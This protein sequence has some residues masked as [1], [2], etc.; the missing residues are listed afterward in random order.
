MASTSDC[1]G[2]CS[3]P[4]S[5]S[6]D[7]ADQNSKSILRLSACLRPPFACQ[8]F[9]AM[10]RTHPH[11]AVQAS[12]IFQPNIFAGKVIFVTGG[13]SGICYHQTQAM[14]EMGCDAAI[15][16]RRIALAQSSAKALEAK[17]GRKCLPLNGDVRQYEDLV[18]AVKKTVARY[19]RIDYVVCGAAGNFLS[20]VER[21]S[22]NAFKTVIEIDLVS[23]GR[24]GRLS[25]GSKVGSA[26]QSKLART[27]YGCRSCTFDP[28]FIGPDFT[29]RDFPHH[30]S[31]FARIAQDQ[32]LHH[33][34]FCDSAGRRCVLDLSV[35]F[36]FLA[37]SSCLEHPTFHSFTRLRSAWFR[38]SCSTSCSCLAPDALLTIKQP[39]T[40][41]H[42]PLRPSLAWTPSSAT[43]RSSTAHLASEPTPSLVST[44]F[45]VAAISARYVL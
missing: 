16:G 39:P 36:R 30:Q 28:S 12:A 3:R 19:G 29:A 35:L 22:V 11:P 34:R 1:S 5:I 13:S 37:V 7:L 38:L 2:G 41:K 4:L 10:S 43:S 25:V 42:M 24:F 45:S 17:T 31:Y 26:A 18:E 27:A 32:G 15:F 33:C 44:L 21:M 20:S 9:P 14:M 8:P 40:F 23:R 6:L